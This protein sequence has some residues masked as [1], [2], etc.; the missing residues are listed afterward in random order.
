MYKWHSN[1][2]GAEINHI[3]MHNRRP[4]KVLK[5]ASRRQVHYEIHRS[6]DENEKKQIASFFMVTKKKLYGWVAHVFFTA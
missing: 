6:T 1:Q 3:F 2:E 4:N 5:N